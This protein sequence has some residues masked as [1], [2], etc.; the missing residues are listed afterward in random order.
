MLDHNLT[1]NYKDKN[2]LTVDH[3]ISILYGFINKI[4][5]KIVGDI[6]NLCIT[7]RKIN[8]N[9]SCKNE[10]EYKIRFE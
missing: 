1:L 4:D 8:S 6:K 2:S 3:K 5:F 7:K 9:K 10:T